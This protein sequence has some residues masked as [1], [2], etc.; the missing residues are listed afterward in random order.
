MDEALTSNLFRVLRVQ[1]GRVHARRAGGAAGVGVGL[2]V[3]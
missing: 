2:C 3:G 1:A